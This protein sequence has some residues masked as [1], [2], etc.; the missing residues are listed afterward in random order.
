MSDRSK[1]RH[2]NNKPIGPQDHLHVGG[3]KV[4]RSAFSR[5]HSISI[6]IYKQATCLENEQR[7]VKGESETQNSAIG[8]FVS[9]GW[10]EQF[11]L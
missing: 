1:V 5:K 2:I 6:S 4:Y 11:D 9:Q 3:F 10:S 7:S 8:L